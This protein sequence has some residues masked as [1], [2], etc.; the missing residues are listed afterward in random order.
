[1][2]KLAKRKLKHGATVTGGILLINAYPALRAFLKPQRE[3]VQQPMPEKKSD[4]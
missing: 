1:M 3:H 2:A 4:A